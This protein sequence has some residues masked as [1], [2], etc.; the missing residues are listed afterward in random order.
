MIIIIAI[1]LF[2]FIMSLSVYMFYVAHND[3]VTYEKISSHKITKNFSG[4]TI[5]FIADIHRRNIKNQTLHKITE[6]IDLVLIGGDLIERNVSF[7]KIRSNLKKLKKWNKPIYFVWGNNDYE[8]DTFTFIQ[9]LKEENVVILEDTLINIYK[10]TEKV[11]LIGFDYYKDINLQPLFDWKEVDDSFTIL[12][13]HKPSSF[14][15]LEQA[16]KAQIDLVLAGH[17]HG[18]Q[19]RIFGFGFY[20]KGGLKYHHGTN[21]F[22]TE[23]YGYTLLPFRLQTKAEC[24]VI[25]LV[26]KQNKRYDSIEGKKMI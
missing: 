25:T 5:F 12:L 24:H 1:I 13:T 20:Q 6:Q 19:I 14:Y 18:G 2:L 15:E 4:F 17:T 11:Q 16:K 26:H 8:I 3:T 7:Q 22:I 9:L 23:G 21:I 10:G